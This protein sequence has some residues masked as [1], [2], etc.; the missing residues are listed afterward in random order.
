MPFNCETCGKEFTKNAGLGKHKARK[1]PCKAPAALIQNV[2]EQAGVTHEPVSEFR[3]TSKKFNKSL[4]KDD[5]ADQGI[6]FTPKKARDYLFKV[7][8]DLSVKPKTILEPSFGTGEF[9]LDAKQKFPES[10]ILGV[11]KHPDLFASVKCEGAKLSNC[12]FL[13]WAGS[14]D[15]IIGNPPYF[16]LKSAE[17]KFAACMTGRANIY[18]MFLYKCLHEHLLADGYLAFIIPTSIYN[19][20]YYQPM[21]NYIVA[22]TTIHHLETLD[23]PGF[24]QTGQETTLVVLQKK[25]SHSNFVFRP[26]NGLTY[27][28][29]YYK[30]LG[31][32]VQNTSTLGNL[33]L[34]VKTGNLV[35]NQVKENLSDTPGTLLVYSSNILNNELVINN[36][37][38]TTRKQY[39]TGITKPT[40]RGPV[41]LVER[42]YGNSL[43]FNTTLVLTNTEFY[44]ENHVNVIY[45]R[46]VSADTEATLRRVIASLQD[47]RTK[48]FVK[49]FSANGMLSASELVDLIPIFPA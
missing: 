22:N 34:G 29:P 2:L 39:V 3:E 33:G 31:E 32:L 17:P 12:D 47:A 15:L 14:A 42:G 10:E 8:S 38:G 9:L 7:L 13:A 48:Q 35:W 44:A 43:Q 46:A 26:V 25:K 24:F 30:E 19:C 11:E 5:R 45:P 28:S 37:N 27:I 41:I 1:I 16:V 23:K 49:W 36:L 18:V 6:Y 4:S 20:S 40:I 21:R